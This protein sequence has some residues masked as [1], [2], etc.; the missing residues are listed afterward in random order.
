MRSRYAT[1]CHKNVRGRSF[2][3]VAIWN[4]IYNLNME[5]GTG[6]IFHHINTQVEF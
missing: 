3:N 6:N 2:I 5:S 1:I 4:I